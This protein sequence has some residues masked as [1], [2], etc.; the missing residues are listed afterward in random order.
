MQMPRHDALLC[1]DN[2]DRAQ[3]FHQK[4]YASPASASS[5]PGSKIFPAQSLTEISVWPRSSSSSIFLS[6]S[7]A[8]STTTE[9][10]LCPAFARTSYGIGRSYLSSLAP[11]APLGYLLQL[12][13]KTFHVQNMQSLRPVRQLHQ[14]SDLPEAASPVDTAHSIIPYRCIP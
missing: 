13:E 7:L 14:R 5:A 12:L 9:K 6:A 8:V 2:C 11:Q 10:A 1:R 3:W 4:R